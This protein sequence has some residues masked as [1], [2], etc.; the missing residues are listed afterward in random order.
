MNLHLLPSNLLQM[1]AV[2]KYYGFVFVGVGY[3]DS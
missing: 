3:E 2:F 1:S